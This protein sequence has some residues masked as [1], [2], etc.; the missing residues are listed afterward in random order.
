MVISTERYKAFSIPAHISHPHLG[1]IG[2]CP[3]RSLAREEGFM[4]PGL[5]VVLVSR[6]LFY[7]NV[8]LGFVKCFV[9]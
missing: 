7:L 1:Y 8:R 4:W 3:E 9:T 5:N 6:S 2:M